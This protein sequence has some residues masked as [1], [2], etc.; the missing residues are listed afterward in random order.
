M[1]ED[2]RKGDALVKLI[3]L[4]L[5][6]LQTIITTWCFNISSSA[7]ASTNR[8]YTLEERVNN[9]NSVLTEIKADVKT[10]LNRK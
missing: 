3:L 1:P 9:Q 10:L 5:G 6:I 2:R 4:L 7:N 8:L